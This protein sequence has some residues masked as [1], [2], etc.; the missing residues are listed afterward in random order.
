MTDVFVALICLFLGLV[1]GAFSVWTLIGYR[2]QQARDLRDRALAER[3]ANARQRETLDAQADSLERDRQALA[4][5]V[6]EFDSRRDS[7]ANLETEI[8]FLRRELG[9]HRISVQGL[10]LLAREQ[11]RKESLLQDLAARY[12][13]E[14]NRWIKATLTPGNYAAC[15]RRL[16]EVIQRC[17]EAGVDYRPEQAGLDL[18]QLRHDYESAVRAAAERE[19]QARRRAELRDEQRRQQQLADE[20]ERADAERRM[21]EEAI[22]KVR[23]ETTDK[24]SQELEELQARLREAEERAQRA[25]SQ[26]Q[27]TKQGHVYVISNLGSFGE[28]VYKIGMTRRLVPQE[29]VDE[30]SGAAVPFEFDVHMMI[31]C[32]DAPRLETILHN[33]LHLARVNRVNPRK[34]FFR[35]DLETIRRIVEENHGE[36]EY[37][38]TAAALEYRQGLTLSVEEQERIE[39]LYRSTEAHFDEEAATTLGEALEQQP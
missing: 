37:V 11:A 36:V 17:R 18:A 8:E 25:I 29:R 22:A 31:K 19:E 39:E 21:L 38:A 1:G 13:K 6:A 23:R 2:E 15:Q 10:E 16:Q 5:Q 12:L 4:R 24:H 32:D 28:G 34:E 27:L 7:M 35:V 30:L 9:A 14:N 20:L 3:E 26:A 33:A